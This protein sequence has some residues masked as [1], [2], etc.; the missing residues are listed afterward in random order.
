MV[1][2][3]CYSC[4]RLTDDDGTKETGECKTADGHQG[5]DK[6]KLNG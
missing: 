5:K 3:Y 4:V 6:K 2:Y 1:I